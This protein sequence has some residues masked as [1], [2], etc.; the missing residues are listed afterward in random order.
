MHRRRMNHSKIQDITGLQKEN[1]REHFSTY[2]LKENEPHKA[3]SAAPRFWTS[4]DY[5]RRKPEGNRS[6]PTHR[7][8][9]SHTRKTARLREPGQHQ[10]AEGEDQKGSRLNLHTKENEP[11]QA[12]SAA[13]R[14]R[15]SL[16]YRR[17]RPEGISSQPTHQR[18]MNHSKIQDITGLQKEKK[19]REPF[20]TY[21][22]KENEPHKADSAAPRFW[23]SLDYRRRKPE[24]NRSR[25][26]HRRR[27][28]HTRKT[29]RLREPGQHQT[30]EGEDQKGSRLNLRTE[31]E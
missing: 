13:P 6:R 14:S 25:P 10:T 23:T 22:L 24:G 21:A 15:T 9:M 29:A 3:D 30:A 31:G 7:R 1:R 2:A 16:D 18:R 26:T 11:H 5:R 8:R 20:S 17:R 4:L 19:G 12:D 28:S 27:M